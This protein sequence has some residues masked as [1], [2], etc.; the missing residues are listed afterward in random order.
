MGSVKKTKPGMG[1]G[2]KK[3]KLDPNH[4][5]FDSEEEYGNEAKDYS[6]SDEEEDEEEVPLKKQP[7]VQ[8]QLPNEYLIKREATLISILKKSFKTRVI[9]FCNEKL[10]CSRLLALLT[11]FGFKAGECHGN[12]EQAERLSAVEQF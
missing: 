9:V 6:S 7:T 3:R 10:Q 2:K 11:M 12:M 4:P 8:K 1:K 5:D